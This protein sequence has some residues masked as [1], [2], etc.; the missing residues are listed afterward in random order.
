[1]TIYLTLHQPKNDCI[2]ASVSLGLSDL[3][4]GFEPAPT[5]LQEFFDEGIATL[6]PQLQKEGVFIQ[7]KSTFVDFSQATVVMALSASLANSQS[8][9]RFDSQLNRPEALKQ[10]MDGL[11]ESVQ[12]F[13]QLKILE[14]KD[15]PLDRAIGQ[16]ARRI[17]LKAKFENMPFYLFLEAI[18]FRRDKNVIFLVV[19][20]LNQPPRAIE[21][22]NLATQLDK[23]L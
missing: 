8:L 22:Q 1:M 2:L 11:Q 18:A 6:K 12:G 7:E 19:S 10:L 20:A 5:F 14:A 21:L 4:A 3:P 23:R 13:G 15:L 17:K 9:K 16:T